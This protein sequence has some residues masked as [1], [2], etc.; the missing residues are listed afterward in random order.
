M[1]RNNK[2]QF[3]IVDIETT[4]GNPKFDKITEIAIYIYDG[5]KIIDE[6]T[7]LINPEC[8]I[9]SFITQM[10]GIT[11]EMVAEAP[12]F[13]EVAKKIVEI[14]DN[15][16]F[17]AH[18]VNFDYNFIKNEFLRLGYN[19]C[20][21]KLCTVVLSRKA[22]PGKKS[23]SLGNITHELGIFINNRHRAAGDA[24]ATALLFDK[25]FK[26]NTFISNLSSYSGL[27][28]D[29]VEKI[30]NLPE[31]T[32]IYYFYNLS[33]EIIYIGKSINIKDRVYSHFYNG[34]DQ[35]DNEM[36]F[37]IANIS[38]EITGSEMIALITES[39]EIKKHKPFYNRLQRKKYDCWG[40]YY[41]Y[42]EN[43]YICLKLERNRNMNAIPL[44]SFENRK[45]ALKQLNDFV[46]KYQLCQ[47]LCELYNSNSCCFHYHIGQCK[48]AC[49]NEEPVDKY[50]KRV[51]QLLNS[52][53]IFKNKSFFIIDKGRNA[54]EKAVIKIENGKFVGFGYIGVQFATT[55]N[56]H[57]CIVSC[58]D[59]RDVISIIKRNIL[60]NNYEKIIYF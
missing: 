17:V 46:E 5:E 44:M 6:F 30:N 42:N 37:Q 25:I 34:N 55:E 29:I 15:R 18:N 39:L 41:Y 3:A 19:Y 53:N 31:D 58:N 1:T 51:L 20:R 33:S 59:N 57:D 21:K 27:N 13:F 43:N 54:D 9:P 8:N 48:G 56:L 47:K 49:V 22:F 12:K 11:N 10:T 16:I 7:T 38:F 52:L 40:I 26:Q 23:Y 28:S 24:F 2:V 14:T 45:E 50:N 36:K 4:G 32:G 60:K 35:K